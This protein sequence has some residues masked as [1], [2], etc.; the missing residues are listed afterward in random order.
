MTGIEKIIGRIEADAA[1]EAG[2]LM[3]DAREK[4]D[5]IRADFQKKADALAAEL[6]SKGSREAS[7]RRKRAVGV[8]E[9]EARKKLLE[10]KQEMI[11]KA[12]AA[13]GEK[14]AALSKKELI[15]ILARLAAGAAAGDEELLLTAEDRESIGGDVVKTANKLLKECGKPA[16]LTLSERSHAEMGGVV[17][18]GGEVEANC[19]FKTLLETLRGEMAADVAGLLFAPEAEPCQ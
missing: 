18:S 14:L 19:T 2:R 12:F 15:P 13:A 1:A 11:D 4:A 6:L 16:S 17:L 9:L 7:E 5:G 8:A 10:A 3:D